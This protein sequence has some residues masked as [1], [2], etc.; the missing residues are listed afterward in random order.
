MRYFVHQHKKEESKFLKSA[1]YIGN[2][3]FYFN[4]KGIYVHAVM[5]A[6]R[7]LRS[8]TRFQDKIKRWGPSGKKI[9]I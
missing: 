2:I 4:L 5:K 7:R 3:Y 1:E 6:T 8:V 9:I